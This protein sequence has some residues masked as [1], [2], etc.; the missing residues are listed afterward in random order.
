MA[1]LLPRLELSKDGRLYIPM[2]EQ[3]SYIQQMKFDQ[4]IYID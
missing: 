3:A 2:H 4:D 1:S